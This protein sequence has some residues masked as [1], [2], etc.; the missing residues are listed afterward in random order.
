MAG[1][2]TR[3]HAPAPSHAAF[4]SRRWQLPPTLFNLMRRRVP[5][6]AAYRPTAND[7]NFLKNCVSECAA[8]NAPPD[9]RQRISEQKIF[10]DRVR[11]TVTQWNMKPDTDNRRQRDMRYYIYSGCGKKYFTKIIAFSQQSL[12]ISKPNFTVTG[13]VAGGRVH[14]LLLL[15]LYVVASVFGI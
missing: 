10:H 9:T 4:H 3:R 13:I 11:H 15:L 5:R 8:F 6:V 1:V 12:G 7:A 14:R 2:I